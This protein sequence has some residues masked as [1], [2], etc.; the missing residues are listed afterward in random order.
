MAS[1]Y[2]LPITS[3][4]DQTFSCTIPINGKNVTL[5]FRLRYNDIAKYWWLTIADKDNKVLIDS[6]P[7]LSPASPTGNILEQY[8]YLGIGSAYLVNAGG[9]LQDSPDSS[10]LG[11]DFLLIWGDS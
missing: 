9:T 3:D 8:Q 11:T 1:Y 2:E 7:L 10:N 4:P 5:N 6:L